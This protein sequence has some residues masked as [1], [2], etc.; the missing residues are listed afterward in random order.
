MSFLD[1]GLTRPQ[2]QTEHTYNGVK[3]SCNPE[4]LCSYEGQSSR[5]LVP[6]A[7]VKQEIDAK[8]GGLSAPNPG[9][10]VENWA[11]KTKVTKTHIAMVVALFAG[12]IYA[13]R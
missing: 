10:P 2:V 8:K 7:Q 6:L 1:E 12:I 3:I 4:G 11:E 13:I 9:L 5:N